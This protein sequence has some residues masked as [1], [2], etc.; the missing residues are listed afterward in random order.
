MQSDDEQPTEE[1]IVRLVKKLQ[2]QFEKSTQLDAA[3]MK[4]LEQLIKNHKEAGQ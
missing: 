4:N 1:A 3:I 2:E